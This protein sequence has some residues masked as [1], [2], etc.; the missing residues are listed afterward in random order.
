MNSYRGL[1]LHRVF[2]DRE[3]VTP[4]IVIE[5]AIQSGLRVKG[6]KID[7]FIFRE[8]LVVVFFIGNSSGFEAG[9]R[10]LHKSFLFNEFRFCMYI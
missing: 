10:S 6:N 7:L 4:S 3:D 2:K 8:S 1:D 9:I 5:G